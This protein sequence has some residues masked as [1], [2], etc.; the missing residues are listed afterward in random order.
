[1]V[2]ARDNEGCTA[3]LIILTDETSFIIIQVLRKPQQC[4]IALEL[5]ISGEKMI[6]NMHSLARGVVGKR[7]SHWQEETQSVIKNCCCGDQESLLW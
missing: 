7:N 1:M 3:T 4:K 2:L 5:L 6:G